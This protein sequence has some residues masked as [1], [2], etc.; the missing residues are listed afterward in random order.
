MESKPTI[1]ADVDSEGRLVLPMEISQRYGL[2]PGSRMRLEDDPNTL[3]LHRPAT[4]L[5]KIY[6]EPTS[7]CNLDCVTCMRNVW[8]EPL[9][10]MRDD[11]FEQIIQ[12]VSDFSPLPTVFFGGIGE[13]LFHT[14]TINW[15]RRVKSLGGRTELITNGTMLTEKKSR[16]LIDSGLDR[17]WVSLDGATPESYG[18]VRLGAE[19]PQVLANLKRLS[20][21]RHPGHFSTPE[22]GI[23]FVA[24]KSNL[25]DLPELLHI[26][27]QIKANFFSVSN[28]LAHTTDLEKERLYERSLKN[29]AYLPSI[30]LRHLSIPKMDFDEHTQEILFQ[31]FNSGYNVTFAGNNLG[32]S[33][34]VCKFIESG[35]LSIGWDGE[36]SPCLPLLHTHQAYLHGKPRLN[37]RHVVGN[38]HERGLREIWLDPEYVTYREKVQRF[39]FAPCTYCGGCDLSVENLDDCFMGGAP[40]CGGCLWAQG[41]IQCP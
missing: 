25:K 20:R 35:S 24:M 11:T 34:D 12:S 26:G 10:R 31:A 36:V 19:L 30:W 38:V 27:R 13:P 14:H 29:I 37:I 4:H 21:M 22:I 7:M 41:L 2:V 18:D 40:A 32:G 1:W 16:E 28:V 17:I 6:I 39:G 33:N 3:R 9:G 5:N 8:G 23:A 15:I